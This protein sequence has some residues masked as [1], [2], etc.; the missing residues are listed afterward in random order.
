MRR[1]HFRFQRILELKERVEEARKEGE[2][3][4]KEH[5]SQKKRRAEV[6]LQQQQSFPESP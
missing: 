1:M 6:Q 2:R 3:G 5:E 4:L